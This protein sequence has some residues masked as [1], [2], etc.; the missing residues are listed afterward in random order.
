M[1]LRSRQLEAGVL[2]VECLVY[3]AALMVVFVLAVTS[4]NRMAIRTSEL[5]R[6]VSDIERALKAGEL[7]RRDLRA[8]TALCRFESGDGFDAFVIP[9]GTNEVI[10]SCD[11][12]NVHRRVSGGPWQVAVAGVKESKFELD[13]REGVSAWRWEIE[14]AHRQ[15]VTRVR[16]LFTFMAVAGGAHEN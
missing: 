16:P 11:R 6:N 7:W 10:Y 15:K 3:V 5:Q 4:F 1:V 12:T 8:A 14:L 2:L 9:S 13:R